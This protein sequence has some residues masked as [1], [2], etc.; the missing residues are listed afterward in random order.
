MNGNEEVKEKLDKIN[1]T[2]YHLNKLLTKEKLNLKQYKIIS[3]S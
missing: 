1:N 2:F 3:N